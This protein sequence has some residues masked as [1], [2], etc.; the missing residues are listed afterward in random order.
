MRAELLLMVRLINITVKGICPFLHIIK[1]GFTSQK[2]AFEPFNATSETPNCVFIYSIVD[3]LA[4][5]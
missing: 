3:E 2:T 4:I 1:N 5:M